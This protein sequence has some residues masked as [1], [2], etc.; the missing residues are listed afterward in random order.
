M[1]ERTS[2]RTAGD[3][4]EHLVADFLQKRG[5]VILARNYIR[6][7]GEIDI[8]AQCKNIVI[9]VEVKT[10][11]RSIFD[12]TEVINKTKQRRIISAAKNFIAERNL[13]EYVLRFDVA[14]IEC[15]DQG[16]INYIPNAFMHDEW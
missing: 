15:L 3:A 2:K 12:L 16:T 4:G 5:F 1:A 10:R 7:T 11:T 8:V 9:F 13:Y 6:R 14:L